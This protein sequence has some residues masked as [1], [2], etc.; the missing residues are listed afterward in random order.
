MVKLCEEIVDQSLLRNSKDNISCVA[1]KL[2]AAKIG[3]GGGVLK[4]RADRETAEAQKD[5]PPTSG[6][7]SN[8]RVG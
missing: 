1:L 2:P 7:R 4:R 8:V 3:S 6:M 5:F